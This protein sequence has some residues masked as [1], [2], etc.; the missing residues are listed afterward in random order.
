LIPDTKLMEKQEV[1]ETQ[2]SNLMKV[3]KTSRDIKYTKEKE[4][5]RR[6]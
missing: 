1:K 6:R 3:D 2:S 5:V 4:G